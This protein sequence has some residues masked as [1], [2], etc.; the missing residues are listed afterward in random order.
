MVT[1][2]TFVEMDQNIMATGTTTNNM[3]MGKKSGRTEASTKVSTPMVGKKDTAPSHG[4]TGLSTKENS[5]RTILMAK[6]Q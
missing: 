3:D 1:A 5:K 6:A 2:S 4:Q